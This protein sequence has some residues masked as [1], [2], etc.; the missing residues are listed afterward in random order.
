MKNIKYFISFLSLVLL[1][2]SCEKEDYEFG[3]IVAPTNLT[4]TP[5][6]VGKDAS[7]PYGDGSGVVNIT[8]KA[9]NAVSYKFIH[10][11][12]EE[13]RSSG[14]KNYNF[15]KTGTNKYIVTVVAT[16]K[17]GISSSATIEFEV[18][19]V[20]V[21]PAELVTMLNANSSRTWRIKAEGNNH[22]GLG[23][24]GGSVITEWYGAPANAKA[25]TGMY[26]DRFTFNSDL[27]FTHD[28]GADGT[29]FGRK[30]LIEELNGPGGTGEGDDIIQYPYAS[31]TGQYSFSAPNG[32]ETITLSGLGF[33]GYYTGGSHQYRIF[34]REK[35]NNPN[36]LV[37]STVDG[38]NGFEWWFVLV[39]A[40]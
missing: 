6:I 4:I 18:L 39:P 23:P 11:G 8:A 3:D 10:N 5:E 22:F 14:F 24:V 27:S 38:N 9:D 34:D 26:D 17:G 13:M 7:N 33:I 25:N 32:V 31:N 40:E 37:L 29:V 36:E 28:T 19:V 16:G 20:Y 35:R 12:T 2:S 21:P 30:T 15:A 1:L